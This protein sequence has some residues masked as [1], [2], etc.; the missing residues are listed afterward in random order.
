MKTT[1]APNDMSL[2][3]GSSVGIS[4]S[5]AYQKSKMAHRV[6]SRPGAWPPRPDAALPIL[7]AW[8]PVEAAKTEHEPEPHHQRVA[9]SALT[10][11]HI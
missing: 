10:R 1:N 6:G 8:N 9:L 7:K 2:R 4:R 3:I 5:R 11:C